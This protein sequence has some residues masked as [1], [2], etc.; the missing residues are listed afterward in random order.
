MPTLGDLLGR[1]A[2]DGDI[3]GFDA[4]YARAVDAL[5]ARPASVPMTPPSRSARRSVRWTAVVAI[6]A[7]AAIAV[8]LIV[9]RSNDHATSSTTHVSTGPSGAVFPNVVSATAAELGTWKWTWTAPSEP[10][11]DA[12]VIGW[13]GR[14]ILVH[15][16]VI[17]YH[18]EIKWAPAP[19]EVWAYTPSTNSWTK[20]ASPLPAGNTISVWTGREMLVWISDPKRGLTSGWSYD[21]ATQRWQRI[22]VPAGVCPLTY[23]VWTGSE[24]IVFSRPP[25]SS[26]GAVSG[27]EDPAGRSLWQMSAYNV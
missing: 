27:C 26:S 24:A 16:A 10:L 18:H 23:P 8:P 9:T 11:G 21:P 5:D 17:P 20:L 25:G 22:A 19:N 1:L 13:D 2:D 15:A 14:E 3:A 6:A 12:Q 7:A 4:V